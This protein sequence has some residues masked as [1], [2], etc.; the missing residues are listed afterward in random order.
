MSKKWLF[1]L[2]AWYVAWSVVASV[3][4]KKKWKDVKKELDK[5]KDSKEDTF[6]VLLN[7]FVDTQRNLLDAIKEEVLTDENKALYKEKKSEL[8]A[9]LEDYKTDWEKLIEQLKNEGWDIV[10]VW[11]KRIEKL[12][13]EKK[14]KIDEL[15]W[16][17]PEIAE[18]IKERLLLSYE[19]FKTKLKEK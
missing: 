11:K 17:V 4:S 12:Y 15:I 6:K 3:F 19:D 7:N 9:V 5:V 1:A 10:K 18:D 16:D 13:E 14:D 2:V 8:L